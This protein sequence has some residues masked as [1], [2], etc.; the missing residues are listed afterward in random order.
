MEKASQAS[1][2]GH[3]KTQGKRFARRSS[4]VFLTYQD[5]TKNLLVKSTDK[6]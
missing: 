4:Q 3:L 1:E 2:D 5:P 6:K